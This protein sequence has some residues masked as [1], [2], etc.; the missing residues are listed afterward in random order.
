M[1]KIITTTA[2][3]LVSGFLL[4]AAPAS[5]AQFNG[6]FGSGAAASNSKN[7]YVVQVKA[8]QERFGNSAFKKQF[9][10][11]PRV[12]KRFSNRNRR[13]NSRR[14]GRHD[15]FDNQCISPRRIHRRLKR[16]GWSDFHNLSLRRNQ[17]RVKAYRPNGLLYSLKVHR[18]SGY[19]VQSQLDWSSVWNVADYF[20]S[21]N[22]Q[23]KSARR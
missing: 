20:G 11:L 1:T 22:F 2:V 15:F 17:I 3:T 6:A 18:C 9:D 13:N 8:G 21:W 10:G 23:K 19:L 14:F 4:S 16:Q 7:Q 5:A 12:K